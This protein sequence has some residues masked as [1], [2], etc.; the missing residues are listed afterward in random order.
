MIA[1][2][3]VLH[4]PR[5]VWGKSIVCRLSKDFDL[6][7]SILKAEITPREEGLMVME[8]RGPRAEY[9][10]GIEYLQAGGVEVQPLSQDVTRSEERCTSCGACV[11]VC[12]TKALHVK[13][14]TQEILFDPAKCIGCELCIPA[15]P[16]RAMEM[17][18]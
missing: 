6:E 1:K 16:P 14:E 15:C 13:R 10:R 12:P 9:Q 17:K 5:T 8:L 18:L 4:F 2:K 7:F 3:I 11:A